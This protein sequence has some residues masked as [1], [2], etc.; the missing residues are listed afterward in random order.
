MTSETSTVNHI[1]LRSPSAGNLITIL[2]IDGGGVRGIIPGVIL[3]YLESQLHELDGDEAR[4]A[5]YFDVI[6]GTSTG[7]LVTVMLTAPDQHN[8]P[9]YSA[10]DK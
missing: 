8:R 9:L 2:S 6:A 3:Q 1:G 10:K 4:L 5:D 7:G